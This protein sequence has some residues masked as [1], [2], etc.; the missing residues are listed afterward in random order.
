MSNHILCFSN[1]NGDTNDICTLCT[2]IQ[3]LIGHHLHTHQE[4]LMYTHCLG[5]FL[6][7][8]R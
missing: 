4:L 2:W 3:F 7:A 8:H 6:S 5:A 1:S